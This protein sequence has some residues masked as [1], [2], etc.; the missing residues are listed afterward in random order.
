MMIEGETERLI[1]RPLALEDAEQIQ[2]IFPRWEVIQYLRNIV[3]WPY[4]PDGAADYIRKMA[5]PAMERGEEYHWTL[6]LRAEP[7]RVIGVISLKTND[8]DHRGFW[9]GV[10]W[11]GQGLMSEACVWANDFWFETL[12]FPLLR[13]SKAAANRTSR[14]ISEKQGMRLVG[15]HEKDFVAGRL[16]SEMWEITA[17]EWR[18]WKERAAGC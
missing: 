9:L 5:L 7:E 14:R 18:S 15:V 8:D 13:A 10:P 17:E 2:E 4:P 12:G 6:R 3:P 11:H 1:L 16:P